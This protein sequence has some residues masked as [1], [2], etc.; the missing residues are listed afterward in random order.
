MITAN[1]VFLDPGPCCSNMET[2]DGMPIFGDIFGYSES[3]LAA[4]NVDDFRDIGFEHGDSL[5]VSFEFTQQSFPCA[6]ICNRQNGIP[7]E[8]RSIEHLD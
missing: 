1:V 3:I 4:N 6:I 7:I 5:S 2:I 8:L